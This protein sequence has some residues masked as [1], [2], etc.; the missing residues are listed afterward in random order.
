MRHYFQINSAQK[1]VETPSFSLWEIFGLC[2]QMIFTH[3]ERA[4]LPINLGWLPCLAFSFCSFSAPALYPLEVFLFWGFWF[5]FF[6]SFHFALVSFCVAAFIDSAV[7]LA[8][9]QWWHC[10]L[11]FSTFA[12]EMFCGL[13]GSN[14]AE[15]NQPI[16]NCSRQCQTDANRQRLAPKTRLQKVSTGSTGRGREEKQENTGCMDRKCGNEQCLVYWHIQ[17]R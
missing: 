7:Q 8:K 14:S 4:K 15:G 9:Q 2:R 11:A 3:E 1:Q 16:C 5:I 10:R 13:S 6:G 17:F 12:S